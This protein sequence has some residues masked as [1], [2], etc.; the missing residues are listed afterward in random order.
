MRFDRHTLFQL[1]QA[2]ERDLELVGCI[3]GGWVVEHVDVNQGHDRHDI[4]KWTIR[5]LYADLTQ[6][7]QVVYRMGV[8]GKGVD[9]ENRREKKK[10]TK[11][12]RERVQN[13]RYINISDW[14][15]LFTFFFI[16]IFL[17][18]ANALRR[19]L[20]LPCCELLV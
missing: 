7:Q 3:E 19:V 10:K 1:L 20:P 6:R 11:G 18:A 2:F 14:C 9:E 8:E 16:I 13:D 12:K 15:A 4:N 5:T 17:E